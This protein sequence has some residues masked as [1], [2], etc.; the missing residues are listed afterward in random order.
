M[1][2]LLFILDDCR[3]NGGET[4]VVLPPVQEVI[5]DYVIYPMGLEPY[6]VEYREEIARHATIY[7]MEWLS[8]FAKDQDI[9]ADGFHFLQGDGY[10]RFAEAVATGEAD[11]LK[12]IPYQYSDLGS[13]V[14]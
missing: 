4:L 1:G 13:A 5:W 2:N 3:L 11:F 10:Q 8:E 6:L 9:Y 12:V 7:D 14:N